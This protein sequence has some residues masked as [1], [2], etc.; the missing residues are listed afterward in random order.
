MDPMRMPGFTAETALHAASR[1]YRAGHAHSTAFRASHL[2]PATAKDG[3]LEWIDCRDFPDGLYCR[4]CGNSG[5]GSVVCCPDD[6]CAIIHKR[7]VIGGGAWP[8]RVGA[9]NLRGVA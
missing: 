2:T 3:K 4:E 6:F 9:R 8:M 5:P 1:K 7:A